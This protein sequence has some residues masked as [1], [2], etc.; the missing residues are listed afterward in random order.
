MNAVTPDSHDNSR[1][2]LT[3]YKT[4]SLAESKR[5][6]L[7]F[8]SE[9][10]R[11]NGAAPA[12]FAKLRDSFAF[13]IQQSISLEFARGYRD[14]AADH[15]R[16][17]PV[18][19]TGPQ[20]ARQLRALADQI[21]GNQKIPMAD[22]RFTVP[23]GTDLLDAAFA[24]FNSSITNQACI[25]LSK[26]DTPYSSLR[27]FNERNFLSEMGCFIESLNTL[28]RPTPFARYNVML[29]SL[30]RDIDY[31]IAG[32]PYDILAHDV[33]SLR[34]GK[35]IKCIQVRKKYCSS[36]LIMKDSERS[37]NTDEFRVFSV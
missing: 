33:R 31:F 21:E 12:L 15:S 36:M 14:N 6:M 1:I 5:F 20:V 13:Q 23:R 22:R 32:Y 17:I 30:I 9:V 4:A 25:A 3:L 7:L 35:P 24:E 10:F 29:D 2:L 37:T 18:K 19:I 8:N 16:N 27:T 26:L 11:F 34:E 28:A